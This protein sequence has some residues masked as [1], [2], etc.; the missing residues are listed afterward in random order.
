[1]Y[2]VF[3]RN[4][5]LFLL[6]LFLALPLVVVSGVSFN[7][8]AQMIFPPQDV[9]LR[10]YRSFLE[11]PAWNMAFQR[12][13]IVAVCVSLLSTTVAMPIAYTIWRFNS[14][15]ARRLARFGI[16]PFLV[17]PIVIG[18]LMLIS[19]AIIGHVGRI[20]NIIVSHVVTFLAIP[21][22]MI[23]LGFRGV[24]REVIECAQTLGAS[25]GYV[26]RSIIAPLIGP[27]VISGMIFAAIFSL[28]EVVIAFLVG[29][30]V[31]QTLPV[32]IFVSLRT[33]FTPTMSV[34]AVLFFVIGV[35]GL[36]MIAR[37][38]NLPRLL[39]GRV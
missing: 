28:N 37:L 25:D 32:Q 4:T 5:F 13:I 10:W 6:G 9:G 8:S 38:N 23:T 21:L 20:E 29:G 11:D 36:L 39:G 27:Y 26:F 31:T 12:S 14:T 35:L 3:F 17:P 19:G 33:G 7:D 18:V 30:F 24:N 1:M 22:T 2:S 15:F 16:L 34:A